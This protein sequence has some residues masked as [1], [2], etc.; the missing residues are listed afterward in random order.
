MTVTPD[1]SPML[2]GAIALAEQYVTE[3]NTHADKVIHAGNATLLLHQVRDEAD[4]DNADILQY[5]EA[6]DQINNKVLDLQKWVEAKI[7]EAGLVDTAPVDEDAERAAYKAARDQ[8]KAL[9]EMYKTLTGGTAIP[10][11][12]ELKNLP[13]TRASSSGSGTLRPRVSEVSADGVKLQGKGP[14]AKDGSD[15]FVSNFSVLAAYLSKVAD[16]KV[17][18]SDLH[19]AAFAAAGTSDL[20]S[21]NGTPIEF[22]YNVEMNDAEH[23]VLT[24]DI[25]VVPSVKG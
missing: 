8:F 21:L 20:S 14:K 15:T 10:V 11:A 23:T 13:G 2:A 1:A 7:I 18:V 25:K 5:R 4:T 12:V 19:A 9:G 24:F 3:A 6:I 22:V 16:R 17:E